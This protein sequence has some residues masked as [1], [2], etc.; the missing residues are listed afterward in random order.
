M[1]ERWP[2]NHKRAGGFCLAPVS[3]TDKR[4][5]K[6]EAVVYKNARGKGGS[7]LP[8]LG[9]PGDSDKKRGLYVLAVF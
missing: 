6:K 4:Q 7:F 8:L 5:G 1:A 9:F 2:V 3:T